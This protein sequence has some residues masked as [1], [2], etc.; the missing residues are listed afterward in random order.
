MKKALRTIR[1]VLVCGLMMTACGGGSTFK[2]NLP[3]SDVFGNLPAL[4]EEHSMATKKGIEKLEGIT[5][6]DKLLKVQKELRKEYQERQAVIEAEEARIKEKEV[7]FTLTDELK[8]SGQYSV[9]SVRAESFGG[10]SITIVPLKVNG[11]LIGVNSVPVSLR[12]LAKDGSI[13]QQQDNLQ[14]YGGKD[15]ATNFFI[16]LDAD[17]EGKLKFA[18]I[19]FFA[20]EE[21][22]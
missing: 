12:F 11:N 1:T 9:S 18:S 13:I 6:N 16:S 2:S 8:A 21:A 19:E 10:F 15:K 3:Q 5:D 4:L 20:A 17:T 22:K 14:I 7:P